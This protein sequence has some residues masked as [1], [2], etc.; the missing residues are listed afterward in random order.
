MSRYGGADD[1]DPISFS[2]KI[3]AIDGSVSFWV[4]FAPEFWNEQN[5]GHFFTWLNVPL[6]GL[7]KIFF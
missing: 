2:Q 1:V 5:L 7:K 4:K 3:R 6:P